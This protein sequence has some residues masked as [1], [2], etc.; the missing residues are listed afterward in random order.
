MYSQPKEHQ[1]AQLDLLNFQVRVLLYIENEHNSDFIF[2]F[3]DGL[4]QF[5][6]EHRLKEIGFDG[7][8][9]DID[10][11]G[12]MFEQLN[13]TAN[14]W[15]GDGITNFF[16]PFRSDRHLKRLL[17]NRDS[18]AGF[19]RKVYDWTVDKD[20]LARKSLRLGVDGMITNKPGVLV[21]VLGEV[22]FQQGFRLATIEDDPFDCFDRGW[23]D[24]FIM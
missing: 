19:I 14:V 15:Q 23:L 11:T 18:K 6:L 22:E 10:K 8:M 4:K 16:R 17:S 12:Q 7:G 5:G 2:G 24:A 21:Q 3:L 13:V 1:I 20:S 9:G